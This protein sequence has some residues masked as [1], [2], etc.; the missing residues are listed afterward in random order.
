MSTLASY[1]IYTTF[2]ASFSAWWKPLAYSIISVIK[3][4]SGTTME[5]VRNRFLRLTG[6][7]ERPAYPGLVVMK[8]AQ[9]GSRSSFCM[10]SSCTQEGLPRL[11]LRA[12]WIWIMTCDRQASTPVSILLNS[13]NTT[14]AP[15]AAI[16]LKNLRILSYSQLAEV[17]RT[18]Q[19]APK[20]RER[21]LVVSVFPVPKGPSG[22]PPQKFCIA[23]TRLR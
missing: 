22:A 16:P 17:F 10:S 7:S 5:T 1:W 14:Q 9:W 4:L 11:C 13:S 18:Q 21:S 15:L 6:S 8:T 19:T 2:Q 12:D 23:T 3:I 20:L